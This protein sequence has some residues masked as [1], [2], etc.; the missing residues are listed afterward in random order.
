MNVCGEH[1]HTHSHTYIHTDTYTGVTNTN[2]TSDLS[3]ASHFC[4]LHSSKHQPTPDA[5]VS[6]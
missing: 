2:V 5:P 6:V 1:T 4:H 3:A